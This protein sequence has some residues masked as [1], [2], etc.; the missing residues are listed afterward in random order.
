MWVNEKTKRVCYLLELVVLPDGRVKIKESEKINKNINLA[1]E[2]KKQWNM[3]LMV[4]PNVVGTLGT[5]ELDFKGR[6]RDIETRILLRLAK[7]PKGVL[8]T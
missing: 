3:T 4:M 6:I 2:L 1:W 8:E 7:I 5:E